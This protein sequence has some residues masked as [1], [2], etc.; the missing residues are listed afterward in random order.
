MSVERRTDRGLP[1]ENLKT[2]FEQ[3]KKE[4]KHFLLV[5]ALQRPKSSPGVHMFPPSLA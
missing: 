2:F 3:A 4:V 1:S 5:I